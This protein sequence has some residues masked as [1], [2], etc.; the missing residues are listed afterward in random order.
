MATDYNATLEQREITLRIALH[1]IVYNI[2][3][4]IYMLIFC[5]VYVPV[6]CGLLNILVQLKFRKINKIH[7]FI[8][9]YELLLI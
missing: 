6:N 9:Y 7:E 1:G 2:N 8:E 4:F 3:C 5:I